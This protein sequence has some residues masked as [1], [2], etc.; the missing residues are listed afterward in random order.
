MFEKKLFEV[1]LTKQVYLYF[2]DNV[3]HI[4]TPN[5]YRKVPRISRVYVYWEGALQKHFTL[6][7]SVASMVEQP[8]SI[9]LTHP[10]PG[11]RDWAKEKLRVALISQNNNF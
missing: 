5:G 6:N 1:Q 7:Y 8:L 3:L 10:D 2:E 9:L 11:A 4:I